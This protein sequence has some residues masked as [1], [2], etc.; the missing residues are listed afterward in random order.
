MCYRPLN[1]SLNVLC[2][3]PLTTYNKTVKSRPP[4]LHDDDTDDDGDDD[5]D[6][7]DDFDVNV[8]DDDDENWE[9]LPTMRG[10]QRKAISLPAKFDLIL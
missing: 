4:L 8:D 5:N 3:Y 1:R 2:L 6:G 7:D 10:K 9:H